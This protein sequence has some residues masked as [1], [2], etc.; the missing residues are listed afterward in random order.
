MGTDWSS[1]LGS[2]SVLSLSFSSL[3]VRHL[4]GRSLWHCDWAHGMF[5]A[6]HA[7]FVVCHFILTFTHSGQYDITKINTLLSYF[8][9][10]LTH[11]VCGFTLFSDPGLEAYSIYQS[12]LLTFLSV[13]HVLIIWALRTSSFSQ[14]FHSDN[15]FL[16][17]LFLSARSESLIIMQSM[18]LRLNLWGFVFVY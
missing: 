16:V 18:N 10:H 5:T 11:I 13:H 12:V 3:Q 9:S 14:G 17:V 15:Y 8:P 4:E 1:E 6:D 7:S 2:S